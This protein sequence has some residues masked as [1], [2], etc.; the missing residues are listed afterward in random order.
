MSK[1]MIKDTKDKI[2]DFK[3]FS[4]V[5]LSLSVFLYIGS[6]IPFEGKETIDRLA[7]LITSYVSIGIALLFYRKI[8]KWKKQLNEGS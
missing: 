4:F 2:A 3:R 8:S 5:L 6:M 7:L 1:E